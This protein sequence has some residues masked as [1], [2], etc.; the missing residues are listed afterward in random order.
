MRNTGTRPRQEVPANRGSISYERS[1]T[2]VL[3]YIFLIPVC[4]PFLPGASSVVVDG[5]SAAGESVTA[6]TPPR[7]S[8]DRVVI[9]IV[10]VVA[11]IPE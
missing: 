7:H 6:K 4:E 1:G 11:G 5:I 2:G 8:T 9:F 10:I 3:P